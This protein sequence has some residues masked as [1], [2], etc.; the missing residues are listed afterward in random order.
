MIYLAIDTC[1]WLE[2]LKADFNQEDNPFDELL[3]WIEND[4][5][6]LI[7]TENLVAEWN[8]HKA[9]KKHQVLDAFKAADSSLSSLMIA[10][11]PMKSFDA[12][13]KVQ[14]V[15]SQR[16]DRINML[17]SHKAHVATET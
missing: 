10:A 8:R 14:H 4:M 6:T 15:L 12:P 5:V 2:L 16:I 7:S 1:V 11:H 13:D 17:L 3:Y 9:S